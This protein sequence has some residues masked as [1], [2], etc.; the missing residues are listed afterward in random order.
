MLQWIPRIC[1]SCSWSIILFPNICPFHLFKNFQWLEGLL[2]V[3]ITLSPTVAPCELYNLPGNYM[4]NWMKHNVGYQ[5]FAAERWGHTQ[6]LAE[7]YAGY[8]ELPSGVK[9]SNGNTQTESCVAI[10]NCLKR[11]SSSFTHF[12]Y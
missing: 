7:N 6:I 10:R 11:E 1:C 12:V 4:H 5:H 8:W 2:F 3:F 9:P